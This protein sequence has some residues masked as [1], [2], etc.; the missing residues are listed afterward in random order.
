M[1]DKTGRRCWQG[2]GRGLEVGSR[3]SINICGHKDE[4]IWGGLGE[5]V[6]VRIFSKVLLG[7]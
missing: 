7:A 1:G 2:R 5:S 4:E 6:E 3:H